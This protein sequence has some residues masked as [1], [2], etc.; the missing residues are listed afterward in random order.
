MQMVGELLMK[1]V[2]LAPANNYHTV[3]WCKYF[4]EQGYLV[5]VISFIYGEIDGVKVYSINTIAKP[6]DNDFKK[7]GYI[8]SF[9]KVRKL[10][11]KISPDFVSVH[12]ASSYGFIAA[13]A[14]I[15]R[16]T[17]SVWGSDIYDFPRKSIFHKMIIKYSLSKATYI[18][19]TSRAMALESKKYTDKHI[20]ITPFGVD[21]GLFNIAKRIRKDDDKFVIGIVKS[22]E[23]HYGIKTLLEAVSILKEELPQIYIELRI[24]GRGSKVNEYKEYA[25]QIGIEKNNCMVRLYISSRGGI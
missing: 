8:L 11:E 14:G 6:Q 7:I 10:I 9:F 4:R 13:L 12:Y 16:Y 25:K 1:I 5:Y 21:M 2:F 22:L 23:P 24:A 18:L 3:K 19:S 17:L 15:K 20:D